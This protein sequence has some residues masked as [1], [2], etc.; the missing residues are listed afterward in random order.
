MRQNVPGQMDVVG[1]PD[2]SDVSVEL[3]FLQP[4]TVTT[5]VTAIQRPDRKF[6]Y[7]CL[8]LHLKFCCSICGY[9]NACWC[10]DVDRAARRIGSITE[11]WSNGVRSGGVA[12]IAN[13]NCFIEDLRAG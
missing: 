11:T 2:Q 10:I 7:V 12:V 13:L 3:P 6:R 4:E 1:A 5:A 8:Q 9:R